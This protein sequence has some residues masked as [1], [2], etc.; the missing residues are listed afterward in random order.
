MHKFLAP[1]FL[2]LTLLTPQ[3]L[4]ADAEK[5]AE[6]PYKHLKV[7]GQFID[8]IRQ[9]YVTPPDV[10]KL[11]ENAVKGMAAGLDP[12]SGALTKKEFNEIHEEISGT[13][14]GLGIEILPKN[15]YIEVV[16]PIDGTP[17]YDAGLKS[18]DL[19]THVE[20]TPV[21]S[22]S[23]NQAVSQ[24]RGKIGTKVNLT[25][26]REGKP[27]FKVTI[28]R[29]KIKS[30]AARATPME[31]VVYIRLAT[32]M[33][34]NSAQTIESEYK[35]ALKEMKEKPSGLIL[36]LR[37]NP[38]GLLDQAVDVADLFLN[39]G[40]IVS[41]RGRKEKDNQR[42]NAK[43]GDIT[44]NLP[45][46]VL[47]D[48][49]SASASEIVAAALQSHRRAIVVGLPSFGKG[50]VQTI[51]GVG[52]F[53]GLR[54]TTA[55]YYTPAGHSIEGKGVNPDINVPYAIVK[56]IDLGRPVDEKT[57]K[58][59]FQKRNGKTPN[60]DNA[61][62][63][64]DTKTKLKNDDKLSKKQ[65]QMTAENE[66]KKADPEQKKELEDY[67]LQFAINLLKGLSIDRMRKNK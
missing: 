25:I 16:A 14:G 63:E 65:T 49:G 47:I 64:K 41:S 44:N 17:A 40:E 38:G 29:A 43:S 58:E 12:H 55:K 52:N 42:F 34:R 11:I 37:S 24:L 22:L 6:S 46:V 66:S 15:G 59:L 8:K 7:L 30:R 54:L 53:G 23:Y 26:Q 5:S 62:K 33:D 39:N 35:K 51:M 61:T 45:M 27:A 57:L 31:G 19:I 67:Q 36:D 32:F 4:R 50:S 56:P 21:K 10:E 48:N 28:T 3:I 60:A 1:V 20:E 13:F 2:L 18:K 9:E